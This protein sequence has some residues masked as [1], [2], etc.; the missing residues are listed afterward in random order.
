MRSPSPSAPPPAQG[1][2]GFSLIEALVALAVLAIATVGLMR[3][4]ESHV[5]STRGLELRQTAMWVAENRMAELELG[6]AGE[7]ASQVEMLGRQWR[8]EVAR[9]RTDDPEIERV[10]IRVFGT[11]DQAPLASLDG[12]VDGRRT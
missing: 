4:V 10:R 7:P 11:G 12:F 6:E 5:D 2:S 1:D 8:V 9:D 3:A